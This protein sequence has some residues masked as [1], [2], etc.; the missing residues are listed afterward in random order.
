MKQNVG[1]T[2]NV[3]VHII[4]IPSALIPGQTY[5]CPI[6]GQVG[7]SP[8]QITDVQ[9]ECDPKGAAT[10]KWDPKTGE[11]TIEVSPSVAPGTN[12][13]IKIVATDSNGNKGTIEKTIIV[14]E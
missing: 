7:S 9:F 12:V 10:G 6:S 11:L 4:D 13:K 2:K 1:P 8:V 3:E 14:G 5:E